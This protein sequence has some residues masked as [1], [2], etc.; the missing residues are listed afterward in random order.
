[1]ACLRTSA[2]LPALANRVIPAAPRPPPRPI[3]QPRRVHPR[4][5][6]RRKRWMERSLPATV[7][8]GQQVDQ[9]TVFLSNLSTNPSQAR[10]LVRMP[11]GKRQPL[12]KPPHKW[13]RAVRR[14]HWPRPDRHLPRRHYPPNDKPHASRARSRFSDKPHALRPRSRFSDRR[15]ALRPRSRCKLH[16]RRRREPSIGKLP[17]RRSRGSIDRCRALGPPHPFIGTRHAQRRGGPIAKRQP[18]G[19]PADW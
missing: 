10:S 7:N 2:W 4:R 19:S 1:M 11:A 18:R 3:L 17:F 9:Q 16:E 13:P 14:S 15:R 6:R 12:R 8:P 5:K